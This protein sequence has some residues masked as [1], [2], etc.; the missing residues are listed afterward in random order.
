MAEAEIPTDE[1]LE[2]AVA[3]A[4]GDPDYEGN[5][6]GDTVG[7]LF[8]RGGQAVFSAAAAWCRSPDA[9]L[10]ALGADVLGQLDWPKKLP[11]ARDSEP[12]LVGL[13]SDSDADVVYSALIALS[14][15]R[16]GSTAAIVP[17]ASH[18]SAEVRYAVTF[19]LGGREDA[20]AQTTLIQLTVDSVARVRDW[21]TFGIGILGELDGPEIR[22]ALVARLTD[23]DDD[24]RGEAMH[25]L[26]ERGDARA[27]PFILEELKQD[28]FLCV[29]VEAAAKLP[30][31][32]FL[33]HLEQALEANPEDDALKLAVERCRAVS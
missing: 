17:L 24:V 23:D 15:L 19:A 11:F 27:V 4:R 32:S 30:D 26:A 29:A 33:V 22:A 5:E 9:L 13:L 14:H 18:P 2:R 28:K 12:L 31:S 3:A 7:A 16:V 21:A 20:L 25:G 6:R 8:Q 10:R 1:L